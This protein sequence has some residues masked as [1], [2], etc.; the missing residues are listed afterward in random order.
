MLLLEDGQE[1]SNLVAE[2]EQIQLTSKGTNELWNQRLGHV[3]LYAV[4]HLPET[5]KGVEI[6]DVPAKTQPGEP[7]SLCETCELSKARQ[8]ISRRAR[9]SN[10]DKPFTTLHIDLIVPAPVGYNK[11]KYIFH[12][13]CKVTKFHFVQTDASKTVFARGIQGV[14]KFIGTQYKTKDNDIRVQEIHGDQDTV[15]YSNDFKRYVEEKG[16]NYTP[17]APYTPQQKGPAMRAGRL[18][19]QFAKAL[20]QDSG[21]PLSLWLKLYRTGVHILNLMPTRDLGWESPM[22]QIHKIMNRKDLPNASHL[23]ILG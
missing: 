1:T 6:T 21:F 13:W 5:A 10:R 22:Q 12:A 16:I 19:S 17:S 8:H 20:H 18:L 23:R 15:T 14:I 2:P 4:K 3:S 9:S 7:T 11:H